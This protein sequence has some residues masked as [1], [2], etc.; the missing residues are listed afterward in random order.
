MR[1]RLALIAAAAAVVAGGSAVTA[2]PA[3]ARPL[4]VEVKK[5]SCGRPNVYVLGDPVFSHPQ[6]ICDT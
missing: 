1:K 2:A 3:T 6:Q 5:D 4:P